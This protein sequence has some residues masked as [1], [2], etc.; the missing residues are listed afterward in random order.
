MKV[1]LKTKKIAK[2]LKHFV[3]DNK[4][5]LFCPVWAPAIQRI[6]GKMMLKGCGLT[7][8]IDLTNIKE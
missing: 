4:R 2:C 7:N 3:I 6:K 5:V 8:F 1:Y